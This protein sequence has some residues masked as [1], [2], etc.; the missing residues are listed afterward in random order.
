[1]KH[2]RQFRLPLMFMRSQVS[3]ENAF[4]FCMT[5]NVEMRPGAITY[6]KQWLTQNRPYAYATEMELTNKT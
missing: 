3:I 6:K 1:M 5:P 2:A 4:Q